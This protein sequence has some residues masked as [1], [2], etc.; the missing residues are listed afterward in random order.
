LSGSSRGRRLLTVMRL[1]LKRFPSRCSRRTS[2]ARV[3]KR[4]RVVRLQARLA[5]KARM[6]Q[7]HCYLANFKVIW[8]AVLNSYVAVK[9]LMQPIVTVLNCRVPP[10]GAVTNVASGFCNKSTQLASRQPCWHSNL[11]YM[12]GTARH[13]C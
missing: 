13:S 6:C 9:L 3:C 1:I 2:S 4:K 12:A 11:L 7:L 10:A 5:I 8:K